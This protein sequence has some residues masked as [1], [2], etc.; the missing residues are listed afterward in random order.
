MDFN[1][2]Q[3]K[4]TDTDFFPKTRED[5][6][7]D[8]VEYR[9]LCLCGECGELAGVALEI[10]LAALGVNAAAGG[11]LANDVKKIRRDAKGV[12]TDDKRA[13]LI[14]EMG[15]VLWYLAILCNILEVSMEEVASANI[16]MLA[17]RKKRDALKG[18][19]DHR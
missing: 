4:A 9:N 19:G 14:H 1:E 2:Y 18:A 3:R 16:I 5:Q 6:T 12:I 17:D 15:D 8:L 10:A 7:R 11:G 13:L